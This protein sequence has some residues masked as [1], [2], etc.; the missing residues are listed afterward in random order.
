MDRK[1]FFIC[2]LECGYDSV[3]PWKKK[4]NNKSKTVVNETHWKSQSSAP[5]WRIA[6]SCILNALQI[7]NCLLP[8][9]NI[10]LCLCPTQLFESWAWYA[11]SV[12]QNIRYAMN[13]YVKKLNSVALVSKRTIPT[14][15]PP[16]VREVENFVVNGCH[17]V[18]V[19]DL[20]GR[21]LGFLDR[22]RYF[23]FKVVPQVYSRGWV[24]PVPDPLLLRKFGRAGNRTRV[25]GSVATNFDHLTEN[26]RERN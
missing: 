23:F 21:I 7:Q 14:E 13:T 1:K 10:W 22:T 15:R 5:L 25:S 6:A 24:D 9:R 16:L 11:Y 26:M 12:V 17:V 4:M 3:Q 18:S 2:E 8:A 19:T 20:Y